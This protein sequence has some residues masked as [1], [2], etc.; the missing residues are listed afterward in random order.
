MPVGFG[1]LAGYIEQAAQPDRRSR[2]VGGAW[3]RTSLPG[4]LGRRPSGPAARGLPGSMAAFDGL[5]ES[6]DRLRPLGAGDG[7]CY[8][9][10]SSG[11]TRQPRGI[12]IRQDR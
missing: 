3:R 12:D 11:S 2:R 7:R 5:P 9:Q 8:I 4:S 1:A 6:A 10:F